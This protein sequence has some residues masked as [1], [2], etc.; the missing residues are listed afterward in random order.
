MCPNYEIRALVGGKIKLLPFIGCW[1]RPLFPVRSAIVSWCVYH[2]AS[3]EIPLRD[4]ALCMMYICD[5][6]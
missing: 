2:N 3:L 5:S 4:A 6:T 1:E